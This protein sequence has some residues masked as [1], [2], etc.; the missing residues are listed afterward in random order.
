MFSGVDG[1]DY[2]QTVNIGRDLDLAF[3]GHEFETDQSESILQSRGH[4]PL[5][6][7]G[8]FSCIRKVIPWWISSQY[9]PPLYRAL[10]YSLDASIMG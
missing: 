4:R 5:A 1:R 8:K 6:Y 2:S 10:Y 7:S 9:L 3:P